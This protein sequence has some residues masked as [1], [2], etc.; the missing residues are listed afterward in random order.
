[1][2]NGV[3]R[4]GTSMRK[5]MEDRSGA[6]GS[7]E[8]A[9]NS[10]CSCRAPG[11]VSCCFALGKEFGLLTQPGELLPHL[12]QTGKHFLE[13]LLLAQPRPSPHAPPPELPAPSSIKTVALHL[14]PA[15][16]MERGLRGASGRREL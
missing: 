10:L 8:A 16:G 7:F 9:S 13:Q 1:M 4:R 14:V 11:R 12:L 2:G 6:P 3:S 15:P 5:C